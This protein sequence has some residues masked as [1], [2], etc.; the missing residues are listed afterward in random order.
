MRREI[1]RIVCTL[2]LLVSLGLAI[3]LPMGAPVLAASVYEYYNTS[4]TSVASIWGDIWDAQ[5][6]TPSV[7]HTVTSVKLRLYRIGNG[8]GNITVGI[9]ATD[10]DGL[11]TGSDLCSGTTD[12]NTLP[13]LASQTRLP[14]GD[15]GYSGTWDKTTDMYSY[16]DDDP[17][18]DGDTT[19]LLHG[20]GGAGYAL[21]TFS[22]FSVPAGSTITMLQ[23]TYSC[24]DDT[25]GYNNLR[26]A[27]AVNNTNY[28]T[29]DS[30]AN[31]G[32]SYAD[33]TYNY[34]TNPA[35]GSAWTVDDINGTGSAPLQAFGV[36]SSDSTPAIRITAVKAVVSYVTPEWREV[37][38]GSGCSLAANTTYAIVVRAPSGAADDRAYWRYANPGNYTGGILLQSTDGGA[39]WTSYSNLDFMFEEWGGNT[40]PVADP[41]SGLTVDSCS[42]LTVTLTGSDPENDPLTYMIST[43]PLYGDLYDGTGT[44]G[45]KITSVNYTVTDP[46]HNVTYEPSVHYSVEDSFGFKVNDGEFDSAEAT[47]SLNIS[48]CDDLDYYDDWEYYCV[49][50]EIWMHRMFHNFSCVDGAC[51]EVSTNYSDETFIDDCDLSDY[52]TEWVSYCNDTSIW[53]TRD[54]HDYYCFNGTCQ[55]DVIPESEWFADCDDG[56]PCTVDTCVN[57]TC[58]HT[59]LYANIGEYYRGL[60]GNPNELTT[61]ELLAA[62]DDWLVDA[63]PPCFDDPIT[64]PELLDLVDEWLAT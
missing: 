62:V 22:P 7:A 28:L 50:D 45:T 48:G 44:G 5:T 36:R 16:V 63:A 39:G 31:P 64:T 29:T 42:T 4:D 55:E 49:G 51:V 34:T 1:V 20:S 54:F 11:P 18:N 15:Q 37:T 17:W 10:V 58:V 13:A 2:A 19:Y 23:V 46:T 41:Q 61:T 24:R 25:T 8:P 33:R 43:L 12:G 30:G 57:G 6:F 35:T 59:P 52:Y 38:L 21:F 27:L 26:A 40:P 47:I 53:R 3:A 56:D 9:R 60:E 32:S 14:T